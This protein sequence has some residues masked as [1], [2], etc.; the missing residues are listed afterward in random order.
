MIPRDEYRGLVFST[1]ER[2]NLDPVF[3]IG[4]FGKL[5]EAPSS[6]SKLRPSRQSHRRDLGDFPGEPRQSRYP[7]EPAGGE[8]RDDDDHGAYHDPGYP[9]VPGTGDYRAAQSG[10]HRRPAGGYPDDPSFH[11]Y[12]GQ[13]GIADDLGEAPADD[14]GAYLAWRTMA[15]VP[16]GMTQPTTPSR[17]MAVSPRN[18]SPMGPRPAIMTAGNGDAIPAVIDR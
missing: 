4:S 6:L 1:P 14:F 10:S 15:R 13:A 3:G 2:T 11:P 5:F 9:D 17:T 16:S 7:G 12:S 8:Y 18:P